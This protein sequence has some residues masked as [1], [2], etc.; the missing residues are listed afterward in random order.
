M[1]KER[2]AKLVYNHPNIEDDLSGLDIKV[3]AR[4]GRPNR[5]RVIDFFNQSENPKK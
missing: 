5:K 3:K 4:Q 2:I 1:R